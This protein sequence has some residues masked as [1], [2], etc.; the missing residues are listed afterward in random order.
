MLASFKS[1]LIF[2][3]SDNFSNSLS[4]VSSIL[5]SEKC[6]IKLNKALSVLFNNKFSQIFI[7]SLLIFSIGIIC[8]ALTIAEVNPAFLHISKK[9][10]LRTFLAS[11]SNQ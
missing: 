1:L 5:K 11:L 10:E 9:T 4:E 6:S 8:L 3:S 7:S 2:S